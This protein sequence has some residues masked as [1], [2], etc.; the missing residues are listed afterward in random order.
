M[1]ERQIQS[2]MLHFFCDAKKKISI[3]VYT[4]MIQIKNILNYFNTGNLGFEF[5]K[6]PDVSSRIFP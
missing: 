6:K 3:E 1:S 4:R 5:F 2:V